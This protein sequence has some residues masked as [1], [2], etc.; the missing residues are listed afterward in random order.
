MSE[1]NHQ[2]LVERD[3]LREQCSDM[4]SGFFR[5]LREIKKLQKEA[6]RLQVEENSDASAEKAASSQIEMS[7]T[8]LQENPKETVDE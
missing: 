7:T 8:I 4:L 1:F 2:V 6:A 5:E 3:V